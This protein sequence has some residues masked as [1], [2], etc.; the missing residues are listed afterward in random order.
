[1]LIPGTG[2]SASVCGRHVWHESTQ[3]AIEVV[4]TGRGA[5]STPG[6]L[7]SV[8]TVVPDHV[9]ISTVAVQVTVNRF[10]RFY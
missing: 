9:I 4:L 7:A 2:I 8:C 10:K 5:S 1:M 6:R 3:A